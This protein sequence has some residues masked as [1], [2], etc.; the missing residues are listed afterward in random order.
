MFIG[1]ACILFLLDQI[2]KKKVEGWGG[3]SEEGG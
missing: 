2:E 1:Y 3:H